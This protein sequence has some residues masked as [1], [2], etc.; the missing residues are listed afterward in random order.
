MTKPCV[1]V[2][3]PTL[4]RVGTLTRTVSALS[5][6]PAVA[7]II[8]VDDRPT[9]GPSL[10]FTSHKPLRVIRGGGLGP[11]AAR[12]AGV[13]AAS[14][15]VVLVLDDDVFPAGT[16]ASG[17]AAHHANATRLIVVGAMP[18]WEGDRGPRDLATQLYARD[19]DRWRQRAAADD[20]YLVSHLWGG[21]LSLRRSDAL[22]VGFSSPVFRGR[23]HED[24]EFGLRCRAAGLR[25]VYDDALRAV[26][27]YQR[28]VGEFLLDARQQGEEWAMLRDLHP[29]A[30]LEPPSERFTTGLPSWLATLTRA[31]GTR[32]ALRHVLLGALRGLSALRLRKGELVVTQLLRRVEQLDGAQSV[33]PR[34]LP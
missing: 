29:A 17:H 12:Q 33:A 15:E 21:N 13:A 26:H 10:T 16:L 28:T 18:V 11:G 14:G 5:A 31:A 19:Y 9:A 8:M 30:G 2:V 25:A 4:G 32:R 24:L 22:A 6:D 1:S 20:D 23:R 27:C 3:I 34:E 7:E